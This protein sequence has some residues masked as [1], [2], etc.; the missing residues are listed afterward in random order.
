MRFFNDMFFKQKKKKI[1]L[2]LIPLFSFYHLPN[3]LC[4]LDVLLLADVIEEVVRGGSVLLTF[5]ALPID[6]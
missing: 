5:D 4:P 3:I 1:L 6:L 2:L